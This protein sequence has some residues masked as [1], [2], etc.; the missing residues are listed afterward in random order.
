M[1]TY[2][3]AATLG[4]LQGI[5][6][7]FPISSLGHSVLVPQLL[8]WQL[9][10]TSPQFLAFVV[11]THLAT[12]L[13]LLAFFWREWFRIVVGMV[14]SLYQREISDTDTYAKLGWLLV[15]GTVPAGLLGLLF[16]TQLQQ[17]FAVGTLVAAALIGNGIVLLLAE[18]LRK[19]ARTGFAHG[20]ALAKLTFPQA[21]G[22]GV[23]QSLA[24]IPGF[25]RTG[26]AMTGGLLSGLSHEN[27][28]RFSFLLATPIIFAAAVLNLP[29]LTGGGTP[30]LGVTLVGAGCAAI[31]A[32]SSVRFLSYYFKTNT[33]KPFAVYCIAA[34]TLAL[35]Y[36]SR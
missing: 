13:V 8:G 23:A 28:A 14:R 29:E 12:A 35:L 17:L 22:I 10:Q 25:S 33:L 24:L 20:E 11:A 27:A 32:Y 19:R 3:Q 34:G 36:L 5:T 9:D 18:F 1:L 7:L 26:S 30:F 16:E 4:I 6:E 31:A 21:I 15:A 2:F